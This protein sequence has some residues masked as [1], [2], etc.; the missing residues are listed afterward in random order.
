MVGRGPRFFYVGTGKQ[1]FYNLIFEIASLVA[2]QTRG[3]AVM[4]NEVVKKKSGCCLG[5]G[6]LMG[7][8]EHSG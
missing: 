2:M 5:S 8:P 4:T 6:S 7:V 3:K 1:L